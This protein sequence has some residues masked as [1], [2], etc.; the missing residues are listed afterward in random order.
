MIIDLNLIAAVSGLL[1]GF[2]M[3]VTGAGGAI[4]SLPLL[5]FFTHLSMQQAA[6]IALMAVFC[7]AALAT[8]IGL[9]QG[10]V[11]YKAASLLAITGVIFAPLGVGLAYRMPT[12]VLQ[13]LFV[14]VLLYVAWHAF[15]HHQKQS[16]KEEVCQTEAAPCEINPAT[17]RLFWTASCTKR[18]IITGGIAGFL[19][20]LLGVGGGF[21]IVP[22]L[23]KISNL[24]HRM[25]V[26]TALAMMTLVS[27]TSI[28]SYAGHTQIEWHIATPFV[29]A[30]VI[31]SLLGRRLGHHISAKNAN[32]MFGVIATIVAVT[33][34]IKVI[35]H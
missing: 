4:L 8:M 31:G 14:G 27:L 26:A 15:E 9:K 34:L 3:A 6:P 19:S 17:S 1:I 28:L 23:R 32:I 35:S 30:S 2:L 20:G 16:L 24:E 25:I 29:L 12:G 18:L 21:I 33:M 13:V 22:S 10:I 5:L 7:A 11:R